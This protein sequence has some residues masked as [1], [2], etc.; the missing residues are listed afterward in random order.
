MINNKVFEHRP[1]SELFAM[2]KNDLKKFYAENLIDEGTLLKE[3]MKCN[4]KLGI[5][6]REV[7]EVAIPIEDYKGKLPLDLEKVFY[8]CGLHA[9]NTITFSNKNPFN[10][11]VDQDIVYEAKLDRES[12]GNVENYRVIVNRVT[13]TTVHNYGTWI[14]LAIS[15][16][17]AEYCHNDCPNLRKHG[18]YTV[19]I[20]GD[21]LHTPFKSGT[22]YIMYLGSMKDSEGNIL[23]PFHSL[24]H[25]WYEWS[26]KY[27]ILVDILFNSDMNQSELKALLDIASKEKTASWLDAYNFTMN[28]SY[29]EFLDQKKR[30]ELSWYNQYFKYFQ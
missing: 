18:K 21:T 13:N 24:I 7:R 27:K 26:L 23:F 17:S 5:S 20:E 1:V 25:P 12:L 6:I 16:N 9:T 8:I 30:K 15:P 22:I 29:N 3:V 2:V 28:K 10:N 19:Q 14:Q 4:D 11:N